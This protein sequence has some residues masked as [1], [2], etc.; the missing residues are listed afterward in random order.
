MAKDLFSDRADLYALY[1]PVYPEELF[2]YI[3]QF[4]NKTEVAWDCATGNGQ[5]ARF[6]SKYFRRVE[7]TD[8]SASQI[9]KAPQKENIFYSISAAE[10]TSFPDD[11]FD[12][13]TVA[14]A[15]HWLNWKAFRE[16]AQRVARP[17]AVIAVWSYNL[18]LSDDAEVQK[19]IDHFYHNITGPYWDPERRY[20]DECYASVDFEYEP[21]PSKDFSMELLWD[22]EHFLGYLKSWSAVQTYVRMNGT[23]PL[24]LIKNDII[25]AWGIAE[26]KK[27]MFPLFLKIGRVN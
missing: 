24:E 3:I 17:G 27:F 4:V 22:M 20:V 19:I 9:A 21:L 26:K 10:K 25:I 13:I 15:Y 2:E 23:D 1:R 11:H 12:L 14:T 7:A 6:L 5:A 16:E 8:I 18:L